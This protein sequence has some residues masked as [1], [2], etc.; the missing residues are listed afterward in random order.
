MKLNDEIA[1]HSDSTATADNNSTLR[2]VPLTL[3]SPHNEMAPRWKTHSLW[4]ALFPAPNAAKVAF[5]NM[6]DSQNLQELIAKLS[7]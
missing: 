5:G 7:M 2:Q 6:G 3:F 4:K 1:S